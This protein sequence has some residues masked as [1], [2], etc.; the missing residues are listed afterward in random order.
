ML[1]FDE[2]DTSPQVTATSH[3]PSR[4]RSI[5]CGRRQHEIDTTGMLPFPD[6]PTSPEPPPSP[7]PPTSPEPLTFSGPEISREPSTQPEPRKQ[8]S[9]LTLQARLGGTR[10]TGT[11]E[12]SIFIIR[13]CP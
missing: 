1:S 10:N 9:E 5:E 6:L 3:S 4:N 7:E 2:I 8:L 13:I 12:V 11:R